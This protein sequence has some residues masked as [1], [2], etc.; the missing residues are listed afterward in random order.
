MITIMADSDLLA[1]L[2][3]WY[4]EQCDGEWEHGGRIDISTV[5][6]PGWRVKINLRET[7]SAEGVFEKIAVDRTE[8]DWLQCFKKDGEFIGAGDPSKLSTILEH[9][10]RFVGKL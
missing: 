8:N 2:C 5:D 10:L 3:E 1:K 4:A 9:F 6:N 7:A